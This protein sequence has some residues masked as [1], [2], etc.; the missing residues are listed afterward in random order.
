MPA[1]HGSSPVLSTVG[2]NPALAVEQKA[3]PLL[4]ENSP[5]PLQ[6]LHS[7]A[8]AVSWY[9]PSGQEEHAVA[10][11]IAL[12]AVVPGRHLEQKADPGWS[13]YSP[14]AHSVHELALP[15]VLKLPG[16]HS[17]QA[18]DSLSK[19]SLWS[20]LVQLARSFPTVPMHSV[21]SVWP[22]KE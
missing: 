1:G 22:L 20:Q 13:E 21:H 14:I 3:E 12:L 17:T 10:P 9:L 16:S 7:V 5:V 2:W 15:P 6:R 18:I 19:K 11:S 8:P 4:P